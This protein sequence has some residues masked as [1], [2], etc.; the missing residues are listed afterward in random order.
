[1]VNGIDLSPIGRFFQ[2]ESVPFGFSSSSNFS[3]NHVGDRT[4][5]LRRGRRHGHV[6]PR[7]TAEMID[8]PAEK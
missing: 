1:M 3:A 6:G 5:G 4:R 8:G 7:G 2:P